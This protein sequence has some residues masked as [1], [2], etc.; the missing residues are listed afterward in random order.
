[1]LLHTINQNNTPFESWCGSS[2]YR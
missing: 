1:M 2:C